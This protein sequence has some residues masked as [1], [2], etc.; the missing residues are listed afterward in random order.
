MPRALAAVLL[1]AAS[2][3]PVCA[4]EASL[5]SPERLAAVREY[6]KRGWATLTRSSADLL[7][8]APDPKMRLA[9]GERWPVYV[10][11]REDLAR[12]EA[13]LRRSLAPA[14]MAR[15]EL[16]RLPADGNVRR[17]GL[18][19]LP[20]PYVVP[21]GRFNE[22]YGWDSYFILLGL[23][24]DGEVERARD[25][26]DNFV[27]EI[28]HYGTILNANRTYYLTRSQPPFLTRMVLGVYE[29]TGDREWLRSTLPAIRSYHR[30]WTSA[31]HLVPST[32]LSRYYDRGAGPAPEVVSDERDAQGRTHYDRVREYYRTHSVPDY[33]VSLFYDRA[34]DRLTPLFYKG[35]RSMRESGFDPSNRFGPFSADIVHYV[36]VCLN[37]L[38]YR[39]ERDTADVLSIL[40]RPAEA[41]GWEGRAAARRVAMDRYL[42]DE[43]AGLYLDY[44]FRR[45]RRRGYAF[46]TT[47]YPLWAGQASP[48]QAARVLSGLARFEAPGGLRTSTTVSGSQWDA[49]FG[50]APLQIIAVT[51]LRSYGHHEAASRLARRF[52]ALVTKEFEEHGVIVEKY[53]VERRESDVSA[54]LRYGY[55]SNEVGFGWTNAAFLDLLA[56][57][58]SGRGAAPLLRRRLPDRPPEP[59]RAQADAG[60]HRP[61][62]VDGGLRGGGE[63]ALP[64]RAPRGLPRVR[65]RGAGLRLRGRAA[66]E[67]G[68]AHPQ[69]AHRPP[70]RQGARA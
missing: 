11:A 40:G 5:P 12:V 60:Q 51:G 2:A 62:A 4:D 1:L 34:R 14:E 48:A 64:P 67:A 39:M 36:P 38:L 45:G 6:I 53:D 15:I 25:M 17:H 19:Y 46:A 70:R 27:Y 7:R 43:E 35:D 59:D 37:A 68:R 18:L 23:L 24:R 61:H 56:G 3:A 20:R 30:F 26:V 28:G 63:R 41:R 49:P 21:G 9:P 55:T 58:E 31:P 10:S 44:D 33:D 22:M 65:P 16:R 8:A 42:W 47:F 69:R 13:D 52:V 57:L 54:G 50:W 29:R 32:G 66:G